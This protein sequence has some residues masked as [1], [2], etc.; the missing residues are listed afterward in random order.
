MATK[1]KS[2]TSPTQKTNELVTAIEILSDSLH[3]S[4]NRKRINSILSH[5]NYWVVHVAGDAFSHYVSVI[6]NLTRT[7]ERADEPVFRFLRST[8]KQGLPR[9]SF[10]LIKSAISVTTEQLS[11]ITE[12]PVRTIARRERFKP[13]ESERILRVASAFQKT[14]ELF[15]DLQKARRW[16]TTPK[17]ALSGLSPLECCDTETGSKEVENLLGRI[18]EGVYA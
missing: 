16:F 5:Q 7:I 17:S 3:D 4:D 1:E 13:D 11:L 8:V 15:E 14:L 9:S 10:D 12:I 2:R 6:G 18:D